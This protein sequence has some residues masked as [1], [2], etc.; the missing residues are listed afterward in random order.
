M[1]TE[2]CLCAETVWIDWREPIMSYLMSVTK[3]D[4][5]AHDKDLA[6]KAMHFVLVAD[7][8]YKRGFLSPLLRCV[9]NNQVEYVL[10]E[11]YKGKC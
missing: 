11:L 10:N 2:E 9:D 6:K 4:H 5:K 1:S 3:G 7:N 8:F